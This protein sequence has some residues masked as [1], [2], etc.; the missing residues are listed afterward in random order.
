MR[1]PTP[2]LALACLAVPLVARAQPFQG[3]Y[4]GAGAGY[5][6]P[7]NVPLA[8]VGNYSRMAASWVSAVSATASATAC[9]L[10]WKAIIVMPD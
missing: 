2:L 4:V 3:L 6:L 10:S 1:Y 5:N 7:E 8:G 9:A